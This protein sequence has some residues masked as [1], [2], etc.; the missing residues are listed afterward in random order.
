[1]SGYMPPEA[2]HLIALGDEFVKKA[3]QFSSA[4]GGTD[5]L[6]EHYVRQAANWMLAAKTAY[7]AAHAVKRLFS[8]EETHE[9]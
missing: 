5:E 7:E 9:S 2:T 3:E 6:S 4:R 1:M 8:R